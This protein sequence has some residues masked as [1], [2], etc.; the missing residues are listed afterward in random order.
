MLIDNWTKELNDNKC[1]TLQY[2]LLN[3]DE[4]IR[5]ETMNDIRTHSYGVLLIIIIIIGS[6]YPQYKLVYYTIHNNIIW[7]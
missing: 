5:E 4:D 6:Y 3:G 7:L 2:P 1:P